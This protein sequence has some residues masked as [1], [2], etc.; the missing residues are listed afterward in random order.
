ML[1]G[2]KNM[3]FLIIM[4]VVPAWF[5]SGFVFMKLWAWFP[6]QIFDIGT[7]EYAESLGLMLFVSMIRYKKFDYPDSES[8]EK[9]QEKSF[10]SIVMHYI[11]LIL[12]LVVGYIVSTF[13]R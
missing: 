10:Y 6:H 1:E 5:L 8:K 13:I 2:D 11:Y 4:L 7:I 12:M 3:A 9:Q